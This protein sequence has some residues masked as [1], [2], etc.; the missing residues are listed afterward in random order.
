MDE[1]AL[2]DLLAT[3][4]RRALEFFATGLGDVCEPGVDPRELLYNASVLAHFAQVSTCAQDD[5]P[6]PATRTVVFDTFVLGADVA[7]ASEIM[8]VAG[9]QCLLLTG[10]FAEQMK[11]RHSIQ[12]YAELGAGFFRRAASS[13]SATTRGR[14][15]SAIG[16]G[17]DGWRQRYE[18]LNQLLREQAYLL[19]P[20]T[21]PRDV[22]S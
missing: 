17:F 12:W 2:R 4:H 5:L 20:P 22:L 11:A 6:T 21:L 16:D 15:L 10:F 3:D 7:R 9:A 19:H 1:G 14:L 18:R 8:E 13:E